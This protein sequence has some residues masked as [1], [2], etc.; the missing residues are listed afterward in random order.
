MKEILTALMLSLSLALVAA[1]SHA[2]PKAIADLL[3]LLL[4]SG[5]DVSPR[6]SDDVI[7]KLKEGTELTPEEKQQVRLFAHLLEESKLKDDEIV[8]LDSSGRPLAKPETQHLLEIKQH[9]APQVDEFIRAVLFSGKTEL[10]KEAVAAEFKK[11]LAAKPASPAVHYGFDIVS[12]ELSIVLKRNGSELKGRVHLYDKLIAAG[13]A[14]LGYQALAPSGSSHTASAPQQRSAASDDG[15]GAV[16]LVLVMLLGAVVCAL[17]AQSSG[18]SSI[19]WFCLGFMLNVIAWCVMLY[20]ASRDTRARR[21]T[22]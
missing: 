5:A 20:L 22:G 8:L 6:L 13:V 18:R 9:L 2:S 4:K 11:R 10:S 14:V 19:L 16:A 12:G 15:R 7:K 3:E 21:A 1:Q 17:W